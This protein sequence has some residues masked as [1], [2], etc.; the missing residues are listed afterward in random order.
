MP[1]PN[2]VQSEE[3][4]KKRFHPVGEVDVPLSSRTI[5]LRL[6]SDVQDALDTWTK[7]ERIIFLRSLITNAFREKV[8][9]A[10]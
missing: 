7:E 6:P 8:K 3:F 1:N 2:P 5:S 9:Q 10:S 4:I